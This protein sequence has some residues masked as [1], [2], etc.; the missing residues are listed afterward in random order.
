MMRSCVFLKWENIVEK[1]NKA[2][3]QAC[4]V[5]YVMLSTVIPL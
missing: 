1:Q 4:F 2:C 3:M 5:V